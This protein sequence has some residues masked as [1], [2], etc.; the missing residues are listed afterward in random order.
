MSNNN[1]WTISHTIG[2]NFTFSVPSENNGRAGRSVSIQMSTVQ[3]LTTPTPLQTSLR[4][5]KL[6][7]ATAVGVKNPV[8]VIGVRGRRSFTSSLEYDTCLL[9]DDWD[10]LCLPSLNV[11]G[12]PR[13]PSLERVWRG[14]TVRKTR[15]VL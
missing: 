3:K 4:V 12:T 10:L 6:P 5:K 1:S 11:N 14:N 8:A 13:R 2:E 7:S 9:E 15:A